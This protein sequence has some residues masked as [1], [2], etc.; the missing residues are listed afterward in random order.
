MKTR[1]FVGPIENGY[2]RLLLGEK[3]EVRQDFRVEVLNRCLGEPAQEQDI[4][5][6][7]LSPENEIIA[8]RKL[9]EEMERMRQEVEGLLNW[10]IHRK[11]G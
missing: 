5:E 3:E 4:L 1:A 6:I 2:A 11:S 8:A 10:I 7:T 9:P